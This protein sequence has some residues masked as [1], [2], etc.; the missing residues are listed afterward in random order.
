M[1]RPITLTPEEKRRR[2][3]NRREESHKLHRER[4]KEAEPLLKSLEG[5]DI[6]DYSEI[7]KLLG[8]TSQRAQQIA[9]EALVKIKRLVTA[10]QHCFD[11]P[12]S[13][14]G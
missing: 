5:C 9:V 14:N 6:L 8:I 2:I 11:S 10:K 12:N 7:G 13:V 3:L 4:V 1:S